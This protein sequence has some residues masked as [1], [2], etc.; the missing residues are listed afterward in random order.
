M[1]DAETVP[2]GATIDGPAFV[3]L[4]TTTLV[5]YPGQEAAFDAWGNA[6]LRPLAA[7]DPT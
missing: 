4:P 7:G 3:E 6:R 5:V 2:A 1:Y